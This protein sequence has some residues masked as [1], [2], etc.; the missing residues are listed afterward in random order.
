MKSN[1][2]IAENALLEVIGVV[3]ASPHWRC[4]HE[5]FP[6]VMVTRHWDPSEASPHRALAG[7]F[8]VAR[9]IEKRLNDE[10]FGG[11]RLILGGMT[12]SQRAAFHELWQ[13]GASTDTGFLLDLTGVF[14]VKP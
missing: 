2:T 7:M 9:R 8:N 11:Y 10:G 14:E 4:S 5:A 13:S 3:M 6:L 1:L 12:E